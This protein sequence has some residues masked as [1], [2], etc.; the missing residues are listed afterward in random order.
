MQRNNVLS[1][2][3][4]WIHVSG[5]QPGQPLELLPALRMQYPGGIREEVQSICLLHQEH[6]W[7]VRIIEGTEYNGL[8]RRDIDL[9]PLVDD[10]DG[11]DYSDC[12]ASEPMFVIDGL[13]T[14]T[15]R[16]H[17]ARLLDIFTPATLSFIERFEKRVYLAEEDARADESAKVRFLQ[18]LAAFLAEPLADQVCLSDLAIASLKRSPG[19]TG[20]HF[21]HWDTLVEEWQ[22]GNG[23]LSEIWLADLRSATA[24]AFQELPQ[25]QQL[26]LWLSHRDTS[27]Y[28]RELLESETSLPDVTDIKL[29]DIEFLFADAES[30]IMQALDEEAWR[31]ATDLDSLQEPV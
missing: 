20:R 24:A 18:N 21:S 1:F 13:L 23:V 30:L 4:N 11:Y 5:W 16:L 7:S 6:S 9:L 12:P 19:V 29:F 3:D 22:G 17:T 28:L 27:D 26:A 10:G 31:R 25:S 2:A 14:S 8:S 15:D